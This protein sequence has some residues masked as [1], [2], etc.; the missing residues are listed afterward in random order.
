V[1]DGELHATIKERVARLGLLNN[2][3]FLGN[4]S[5]VAELYQAMDVFVLPSLYEGLAMVRVEALSAGCPCLVSTVCPSL[6]S[7]GH[8]K[9]T[10]L[11]NEQ[12][13]PVGHGSILIWADAI[14]KDAGIVRNTNVDETI[15]EQGY[16]IKEEAPLL[17]NFYQKAS[18]F[19]AS[20]KDKRC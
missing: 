15:K 17:K 9:E 5:D 10:N 2:V 20:N 18:D 11:F 6:V 14:L 16:S 19:I 13:L 8:K 4:R 7:T 3:L 12:F 1:G